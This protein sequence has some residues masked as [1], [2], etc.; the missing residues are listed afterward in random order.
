MDKAINNFAKLPPFPVAPHPTKNETE[1]STPQIMRG[2]ALIIEKAWTYFPR[3]ADNAAALFR[4]LA[5][6]GW[7][8]TRK[9]WTGSMKKAA[10][11]SG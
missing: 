9:L 1:L 5:V 4:F 7:R 6:A 3:A 10:Y 11:P 2:R 8:Y